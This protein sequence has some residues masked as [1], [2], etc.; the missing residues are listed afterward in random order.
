[1]KKAIQYV[2]TNRAGDIKTFRIRTVQQNESDATNLE[3]FAPDQ[4]RGPAAVKL[5]SLLRRG[6]SMSN[7]H[8]IEEPN[9]SLT[10]RPPL[11]WPVSD[12]IIN[13]RE[14]ANAIIDQQ[15]EEAG[16]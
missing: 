15:C 8:I 3:L 16:T 5:H 14:K 10:T 12:P 6:Y 11:N 7:W 4:L 1:M 9:D 13:E 2:M